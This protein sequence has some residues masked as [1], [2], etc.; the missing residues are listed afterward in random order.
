MRPAD[1]MAESVTKPDSVYIFS[2]MKLHTGARI[3]RWEDKAGF[4]HLFSYEPV[5]SSAVSQASAIDPSKI[6]DLTSRM[7]P[8]GTLKW[9]VPEGNWT[10]MRFGYSLTGSKNRPAVPSGSGYEVDK[11]SREYSRSYIKE[12]TDPLKKALGPLYGKS[13]QYVL[14]DSWEAG[15]QNWT[16]KMIEEFAGRRGYDPTPYLLCM[17]GRVVGN[18]NISDRFL[19]DFRRTLADMFAENHFR[20][21]TEYLHKPGY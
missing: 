17:T 16:D 18:S 19:W 6:I 21:I 11:L 5:A 4:S 1:V 8:D 9:K 20:V 15:M 2:E 14:L 13:L 3:N 12:Y 7:S 10:I